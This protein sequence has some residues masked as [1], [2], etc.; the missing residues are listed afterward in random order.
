M[1][2]CTK[3]GNELMDEAVI[4]T[5]CGCMVENVI[6][7]AK[8]NRN[9]N[10]D[11]Q[12]GST[13]VAL[14]FGILALVDAVLTA[15]Y[16]F[17]VFWYIDVIGLSVCPLLGLIASIK[18]L[19]CRNKTNSILGLIFSLLAIISNLV[20]IIVWYCNGGSYFLRYIVRMFF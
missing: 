17:D 14:V 11:G 4:C 6:S 20:T 16:Y 5:K 9:A 19:K 3:C 7:P 13:W 10:L 2:Y 1:K 8:F 15:L 12:T 18:Y